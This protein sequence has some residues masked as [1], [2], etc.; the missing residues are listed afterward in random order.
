MW[1]LIL[2]ANLTGLRDN[3]WISQWGYFQWRLACESVDQCGRSTL[4]VGRH[5]PIG[6]GHRWDTKVEEVNLFFLSWSW[7]TILSPLDIRT[8]DSLAFWSSIFTNA[9]SFRLW[10]LSE[11]YTISFLGS[12]AFEL[13]L[14]QV[15]SF[16]DCSVCRWQAARGIWGLHNCMS[17]FL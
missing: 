5:R 14:G 11:S 15:T 6:W 13:E 8:K 10:P 16:P 2:G 3:F 17:Q 1:W 12:E 7:D 9:P 4:H